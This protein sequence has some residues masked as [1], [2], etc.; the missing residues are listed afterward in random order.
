ME[1]CSKHLESLVKPPYQQ[2]LTEH[3]KKWKNIKNIVFKLSISHVL[4]TQFAAFSKK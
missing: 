3:Y 4:V 1:L 2:W